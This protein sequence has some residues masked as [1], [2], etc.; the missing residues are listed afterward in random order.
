MTLW[1]KSS[2]V[3]LAGLFIVGLVAQVEARSKRSGEIPNGSVNNCAN[4]HVDPQGGG[5]RNAFG[6]MVG[7]DF[8]T[9]AGFV[10]DVVWGPELAK[11][12]ADGDG[13]TNG[14]ELGDPDGSWAIGDAAPGDPGAVTKPWD[15]ESH[16]P[17]K[18][19][20]TAVESSTWGEVKKLVQKILE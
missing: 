15:A 1:K 5:P 3:F 14:E 4:C 13:F 8:L 19:V 6:Q 7:T 16:P 20:P 10:G 12:D 9:G 2:T 17:E 11:L 18:E